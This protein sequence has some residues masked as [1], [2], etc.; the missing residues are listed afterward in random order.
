MP[1]LKRTEPNSDHDDNTTS[2]TV[3][4]KSSEQSEGH[5]GAKERARQPQTQRRSALLHYFAKI[6]R[7]TEVEVAA[8]LDY[9]KLLLDEGANVDECDDFGQTVFHEVSRAWGTDVAQFLVDEGNSIT[10]YSLI[11]SSYCICCTPVH[12]LRAA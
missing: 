2:P 7:S 5:K 10:L 4:R 8:H 9:M 6:T 11:S 1:H 12:M 3:V